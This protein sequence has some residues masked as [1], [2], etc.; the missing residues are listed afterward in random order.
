MNPGAI[1]RSCRPFDP[2]ALGFPGSYDPADVTFLLKPVTPPL[3][4]VDAKEAALQAGTR[5]YSE[6]LSPERPPA[7]DYLEAFH[8]AFAANRA[9]VGRDVARL[10]LALAER[11]GREV[12]LVSLARAGTPVGVLLRR[13]LVRL[14]RACVHYSVSIVRD[15]GLDRVAVETIL[16]AHDAADLVFIDGWTGKGVIAGELRA[17]LA[18]DLPALSQAP[19]AVLSDLAGVATHA[20][21]AEDYVIPSA[22]LNGVVSGLVS[23]TV[24]HPDLIGPGDFHGC[25]LLD[26]LAA[27]DLSRWYVDEQEHDVVQALEG[28][29]PA[30]WPE[31]R[32]ADLA[33]QSQAFVTVMARR[34]GGNPHHVKPGI[35]EST[36]ALLRRVPERLIVRDATAPDVRH[37]L[38]L[39]ETRGVPV[40][41]EPDLPYLACVLIKSLGS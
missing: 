30:R 22:V 5:H 33:R 39:A 1:S 32:R 29:E 3:L 36:R 14:G 23:R 37:L 19:L 21:G 35:G 28:A 8:A 20:A 9:R 18:R 16:A 6:M 38:A 31:C 25:L 27:H 15:R 34:T 12:V 24:L 10:A 4:D 2:S 26:H 40:E 41:V 13:A 11:P 7:A 17:S